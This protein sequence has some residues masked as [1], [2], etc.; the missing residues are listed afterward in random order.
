[1]SEQSVQ[2]SAAAPGAARGPE[3]VFKR[4][5]GLFDLTLFTVSAIVLLDTLAVTASIGVSS[6][7]WWLLLAVL[8]AVP[9]GLVT[10]ELGTT[11][12]EQGGLYAWIRRAFGPRWA[13]RAAWGYWINTAVWLPSIFILFSGFAS[14]LFGLDLSLATQIGV[15]IALVWIAVFV[16]C[17]ALEAGKWVPNIGALFKMIVFAVIIVGGIG[18]G[19]KNG[20]ANAFPAAEMTPRWTDSLRYLPAIIYGMLGFELASAGGEE[21]ENPK[22]NL[23]WAILLAG[24]VIIGLY[25][26]GTIGVLAVL[27]VGDINLVEGL[28]DVLSLLFGDSP[29]GRAAVLGL[30]VAALYTFFSNGV[31]WA[32][33]CN[34]ATAQAAVEGELPGFFGFISKVHGAPIGSA[35]SM[36]VVCTLLLLA[37]GRIAQTNEDLF[38]DLFAFSAVI[39]MLP[40]AAMAL[41]FAQLRRIEPDAPR[42]F[43]IPGGAPVA[44][45]VTGLCLAALLGAIF[46]F[47]YVPGDGLQVQTIAGVAAAL[48]LGE[49]L[50]AIAGLRRHIAKPRR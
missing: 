12:P 44:L 14:R 1:M 30:G 11:W 8:F 43:R 47:C 32:L 34:R 20:F 19:L 27:P 10:A 13:A 29:A 26:A 17:I 18:Y 5:L 15:A 50:I 38:W 45:V 9:I 21:V 3:P 39:F 41:A 33:G 24:V 6:V 2:R 46:L 31:T 36:G 40:Y 48:V 35:I 7:S 25:T 22:R 4:T 49:L 16:N 28:I 42:P 37:Y 23:P